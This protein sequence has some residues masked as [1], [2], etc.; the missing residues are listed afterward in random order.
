MMKDYRKPTLAEK[1]KLIIFPT[2]TL[3]EDFDS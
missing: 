1:E 3:S 2:K